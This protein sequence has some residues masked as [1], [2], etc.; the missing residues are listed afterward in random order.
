MRQDL[1]LQPLLALA[2]APYPCRR[3][4]IGASVLARDDKLAL[5]AELG[6]RDD[7]ADL[8]GRVPGRFGKDELAPG[9]DL[10][11]EFCPVAGDKEGVGFGQDDTAS[12]R[13]GVVGS[14]SDGD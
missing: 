8:S 5:Q 9:L 1:V 4:D 12:A 7:L 11:G 6:V 13:F 14:A 10:R 2:L 3:L